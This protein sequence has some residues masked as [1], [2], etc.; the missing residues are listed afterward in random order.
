MEYVGTLMS[1][2]IAVLATAAA[3]AASHVDDDNEV[4]DGDERDGEERR[5]AP[6][7]LLE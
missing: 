6:F 1:G 2:G 4:H 7:V 5:S 3:A